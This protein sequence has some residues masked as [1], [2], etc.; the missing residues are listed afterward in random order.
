LIQSKGIIIQK[1]L[2]DVTYAEMK[3]LAEVFGI[4][5]TVPYENPFAGKYCICRCDRAGVHAGTVVSQKGQLVILKDSR[6]LWQWRAVAGI[7][8]SGLSQHGLQS[9][10]VDTL[11]PEIGLTDVIEVIPCSD[12]ARRSIENA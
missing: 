6:R 4:T 9:G 2:E 10:K 12:P 3:L 11:L 7:A 1:Q 5:M 8:L